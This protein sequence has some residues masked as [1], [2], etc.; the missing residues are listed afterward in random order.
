MR[1]PT[2]PSRWRTP[3]PTIT[4]ARTRPLRCSPRSRSALTR[5]CRARG[6]ISAA[7]SISLTRS[8]RNTTSSLFRRAT[9]ERRWAAGS[10]ARSRRSTISRV[11]NSASRATPD[12]SSAGSDRDRSRSPAGA[13]IP[14]WEKGPM[15]A[16]EWVGPYDDEKLGFYKVAKYYYYPG[17]WEGGAMLHNFINIDKWNALPKNYQ[18]IVRAASDR[19]HTW[20]QAKY[21]AVNP[22]ALKRLVA[23]GAQLRPFPQPVMEAFFKATKDTYADTASKKADFKKALDSMIAFRGDEYLW[24][25]VAELGFDAFMVS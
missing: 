11:L 20:M 8:S 14:R 13:S 15:H 24:W 23:N 25:Q 10:A 22:L 19:A 21:D 5:A 12:R 3:R 7:R 4:L 6:C 18:E 2:A 9:P 1:S 16:A 17:W